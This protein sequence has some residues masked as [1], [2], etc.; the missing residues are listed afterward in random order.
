MHK[1]FFLQLST[2]LKIAL[3]VAV[4]VLPGGL[5]A[6]LA[7]HLIA[8]MRKRSQTKQA[9]RTGPEDGKRD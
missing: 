2:A 7:Y 9:G 1:T 6:L 5:P 3:Q 4:A 8:R